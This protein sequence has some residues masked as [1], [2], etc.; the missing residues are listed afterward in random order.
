LKATFY[1]SFASINNATVEWCEMPEQYTTYSTINE[2]AATLTRISGIA[3]VAPAALRPRRAFGLVKYCH[4]PSK[5]RRPGRPK[6]REP[7]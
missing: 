2:L 6:A 1:F 7:A 3:A 5:N 4:V